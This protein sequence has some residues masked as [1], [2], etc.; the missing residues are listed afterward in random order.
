[1]ARTL[2]QHDLRP[3][4]RA[5]HLAEAQETYGY[6]YAWPPEVATAAEVPHK[7]SYSAGY[8]AKLI[9]LTLEIF[10]N[11]LAMGEFVAEV[12]DFK[13]VIEDELESAAKLGPKAIGKWF[14]DIQ[15]KKA[16]YMTTRQPESVDEY[17][18][19]FAALPAVPVWSKW[20]DDKAF[21]WQ[22]VAGVNP[23]SIRRIEALPESIGITPEHYLQAVGDQDDMRSAA[24]EGRLFAC[25]YTMFGGVPMGVT[26]GRN[27]FMPATYAVFASVHGELKPIAIQVGANAG[28]PV[29]TP[30]DGYGWRLAK[31]AFNVC[32]ATHHETTS[33][34]GRTHMV[35]EAVAIATRRQL[36]SHHPL[37]D[38][39]HAHTDHTMPIN[40]SA[41][42]SLIAPGGTIDQVF[43][44]TI[45]AAAGLVRAAIDG[46]PINVASPPDELKLRGVD[47]VAMLVEY[48]YR[49]DA[50]LVWGAIEKYIGAYVGHYYESDADV[51][52]DTEL[53]AW[54]TEL[55][56]DDGGRLKGVDPPSTVAELAK[57]VATFVWIGTGQHSAVNFTQWPYMSVVP[58]MVGAF[59]KEWPGEG[60][61]ANEETHLE[62][63]SPINMAIL[64]FNTVYQLS[65]LRYNHLGK[66]GLTTFLA[67]KVRRI[68]DAFRDDLALVE[69]E[70]NA[71]E[72]SRYLPYPHLL[73]S[74]IPNSIHI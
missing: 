30:G 10:A 8:I 70:I 6:S 38:L 35:M 67:P 55:G 53:A 15:S 23:M 61:D 71:R 45:E 48:P 21:A 52:G 63:L 34:L 1:M 9:P 44:P 29:F 5:R 33:H 25:D 51:V 65:N 66:Y 22:R 13:H 74:T 57:L 39:L 64:Q 24:A 46:L 11:N 69:A 50:L 2:P 4:K 19:L 56:A 31:L 20:D 62:L 12:A 28:D 72:A 26:N 41:A 73:P 17:G 16:S 40:H 68:I 59:W 42:T 43:A 58:N 14:F 7:D 18:K 47:D 3:A 49:D 37:Y 60:V 27:K 32:D 54:V 36:A